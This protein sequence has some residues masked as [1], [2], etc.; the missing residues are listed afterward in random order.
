MHRY[1]GFIQVSSHPNKNSLLQ[2]LYPAPSRGFGR[3]GRL[4]IALT[5]KAGRSLGGTLLGGSPW[6]RK[7]S[8]RGTLLGGSSEARK[9][10][11]RG[12]DWLW[13]LNDRGFS[14][15]T[16]AGLQLSSSAPCWL[17]PLGRYG[18]LGVNRIAIGGVAVVENLCSSRLS[19]CHSRLTFLRPGVRVY[20]NPVV[21]VVSLGLCL[22]S[23]QI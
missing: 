12:C 1:P 13:Q 21:G 11:L 22:S 19:V 17:L 18:P 2:Y 14:Q 15:P 10:R 23:R 9:F 5:V 3:C 8:L 20:T 16:L 7:L 4:E 6:V